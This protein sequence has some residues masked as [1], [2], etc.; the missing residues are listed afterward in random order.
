MQLYRGSYLIN[1]LRGTLYQESVKRAHGVNISRSLCL[2]T[3]K[4]VYFGIKNNKKIK[5][6]LRFIKYNYDPSKTLGISYI[7][8][9]FLYPCSAVK[10]Y[11]NSRQ[12]TILMN[13][14]SSVSK[15]WQS[16]V[17]LITVSEPFALIP[18]ELY[19][20]FTKRN[21]WYDCPGLFKW[22]CSKHKLPYE[23]EYA[24]KALDILS[25]VI[26]KFL[27]RTKHF[28]EERIAFV[29]I[30]YNG[31]PD[32]LYTHYYLVK[33]ASK[34][35]NVHVKIYPEKRFI[36]KFIKRHSQRSWQFWGIAHRDSQEYLKGILL[37]V[38]GDGT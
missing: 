26:A 11:L 32:Y 12:Y 15:D 30:P 37:K 10:P 5:N 27:E 4:E 29:R 6:W 20:K 28:Y 25:A 1:E 9:L 33:R 19:E 38:L 23:K 3:P 24:I 35:S 17:H 13:T 8:I 16:S 14:L 7:K 18:Y 36:N 31:A 2:Y 21:L 34:I 22:W